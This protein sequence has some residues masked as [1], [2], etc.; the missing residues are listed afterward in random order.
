MPYTHIGD[1]YFIKEK[2]TSILLVDKVEKTIDTNEYITQDRI[3]YE[4]VYDQYQIVN[5]DVV[6]L[7]F[8][9][10]TISEICQEDQ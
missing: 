6:G 2:S 4:K 3:Y 10:F 5:L 7:E 8:R 1:K 9:I